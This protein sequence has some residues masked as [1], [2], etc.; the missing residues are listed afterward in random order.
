[1]DN[2]LL[3]VVQYLV[4]IKKVVSLTISFFLNMY[5]PKRWDKMARGYKGRSC[6]GEYILRKVPIYSKVGFEGMRD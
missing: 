1:M 3:K 6:T 4:E 5:R 2:C